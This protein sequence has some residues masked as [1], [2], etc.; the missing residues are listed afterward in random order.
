MTLRLEVASLLSIQLMPRWETMFDLNA[1]P[2]ERKLK[3]CN[4]FE[5]QVNLF[6]FFKQTGSAFFLHG[7]CYFW[8]QALSYNGFFHSLQY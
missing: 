3:L 5:D 4:S 1:G 8:K 2:Q 6:F 7:Y